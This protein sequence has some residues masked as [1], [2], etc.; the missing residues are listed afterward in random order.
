MVM[1]TG[2]ETVATT[3]TTK[4]MRMTKTTRKEYVTTK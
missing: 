1:A 4:V 3:A 2:R